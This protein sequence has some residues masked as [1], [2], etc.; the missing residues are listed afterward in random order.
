M[1]A[2]EFHQGDKSTAQREIQQLKMCNWCLQVEQL[3]ENGAAK[4]VNPEQRTPAAQK[5]AAQKP[6]A[7][8]P[9]SPRRSRSNNEPSAW[10]VP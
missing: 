2:V 6:A 3:V 10:Y 7:Q 8:K 4:K 9:A 1:P 5:P